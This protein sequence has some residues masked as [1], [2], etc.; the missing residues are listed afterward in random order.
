MTSPLSTKTMRG[1]EVALS[2]LS[3]RQQR[4]ADNIANTDTPGFQARD[5]SFEGA[6]KR[7]FTG[8]DKFEMQTTS[9]E[10]LSGASNDSSMIQQITLGATALRNDGNNVDMDQ[11]MATLAETSIRFS[12][13]SHLVASKYASLKSAI[14]EGRR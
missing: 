8:G 9:V 5:V 12:A 1:L 2:G 6:L 3:Q 10:H 4:V 13:V 14:N 7:A 11:Q